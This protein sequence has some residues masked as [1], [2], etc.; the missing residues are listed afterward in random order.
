MTFDVRHN[1]DFSS[2]IKKVVEFFSSRYHSF[3]MKWCTWLHNVRHFFF[4]NEKKRIT[5]LLVNSCL[6]SSFSWHQGSMWSI[7]I[8]EFMN[9]IS[10]R[11]FHILNSI[12][13]KFRCHCNNGV[14]IIDEQNFTDNIQVAFWF[15]TLV[16]IQICMS[17]FDEIVEQSLCETCSLLV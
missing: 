14:T 10:V 7:M 9:T 16:Y 15:V 2:D 11:L 12:D 3:V 13:D 5:I 6:G 1:L 4:E 17:P 8:N